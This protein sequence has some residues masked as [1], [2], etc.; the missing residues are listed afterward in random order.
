MVYTAPSNPGDSGGP[1]FNRIGECI[2]I[3]KSRTV[4]VNGTAAEAYAN[5]TPMDKIDELLKKWTDANY[6]EL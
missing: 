6:I 3:N 2:G 4:A 5:A 1:V